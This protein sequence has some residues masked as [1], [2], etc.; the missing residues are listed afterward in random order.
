MNKG[1]NLDVRR[2]TSRFMRFIAVCTSSFTSR[3]PKWLDAYWSTDWH[4]RVSSI[5]CPHAELGV[6]C[7]V[8]D[9]ST[10][11][12]PHVALSYDISC[13]P[14][15]FFE[16]VASRKQAWVMVA[17]LARTTRNALIIINSMTQLSFQYWYDL[18]RLAIGF[19]SYIHVDFMILHNK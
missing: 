19:N 2:S 9:G 1:G 18:Q 10:G 3:R 12:Q 17:N 11:E 14:G 8:A 15:I 6:S 4:A 13:E 5:V 7:C 16:Q